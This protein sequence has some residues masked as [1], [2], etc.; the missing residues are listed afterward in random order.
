MGKSRSQSDQPNDG[1]GSTHEPTRHR[2]FRKSPPW[3]VSS[4]VHLAIILALA[5]L[6]LPELRQ[7]LD[8]ALK[9]AASEQVDDIDDLPNF[10]MTDDLEVEV[11][12]P[13]S[14][15]DPSEI[16][17]GDLSS[18]EMA[19]VATGVSPAELATMMGSPLGDIGAALTPLGSGM[20]ETTTFFGQ[21]SVANR[22]VFMVDNSNSMTNGKLE[23]ALV[24]LA[25]TIDT[26]RPSQSF[27]IIFYSD[28]AYPLFHPDPS[29]SLVKATDD[30]KER[31]I[32]WL[33]TIEMCLRTD[34]RDALQLVRE[35]RPNL[36]YLLGDGAFTDNT[37]KQLVAN[38]MT[39]VVI[40]TLGM[41]VQ[42]K[43]QADFRAIAEQHKG[44]YRDVGIT[45]EG[46]AILEQMGPRPRHRTR[47]VYWG[48]KLP[49]KQ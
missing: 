29:P 31:A 28:T 49:E 41:Q 39:G 25:K 48:L 6:S 45:A 13:L 15:F 2:W 8:F 18:L 20:G 19:T 43:N 10:Q 36:V 27:T 34:G 35:L 16:A 3:L 23:T 26:L 1:D 42:Q 14:E 37:A 24:E 22:I 33:N 30:N 17:L 12:T 47:D 44:T 11:V 9:A 7:E 4:L 21:K 46:K 40:H 5:L 32:D 38:P